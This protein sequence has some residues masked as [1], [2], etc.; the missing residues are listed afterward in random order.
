MFLEWEALFQDERHQQVGQNRE[1]ATDTPRGFK[2][3]FGQ[4]AFST[5]AQ[6]A[7]QEQDTM[8]RSA[9]ATQ[10]WAGSPHPQGHKTPTLSIQSPENPYLILFSELE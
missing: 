5:G 1:E 4:E 8:S 6:Q 3:L 2:E 9:S 10:A 7:T